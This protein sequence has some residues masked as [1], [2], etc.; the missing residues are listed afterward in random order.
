MTHSESQPVVPPQEA[1][2]RRA[3][4]SPGTPST[5]LVTGGAGFIGSHACVELLDHG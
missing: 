3:A 4:R 2:A 1:S 5:V